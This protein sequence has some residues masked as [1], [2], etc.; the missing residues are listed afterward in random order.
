MIMS[1]VLGEGRVR[2]EVICAASG[3]KGFEDFA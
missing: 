3:C 2:S 1:V